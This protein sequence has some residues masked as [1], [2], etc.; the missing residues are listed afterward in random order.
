MIRLDYAK[1]I[2]SAQPR[3][4]PPAAPTLVEC[5]DCEGQSS[6]CATCDGTGYVEPVPAPD[7]DCKGDSC[8][9]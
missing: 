4:D 6:D 2:V 7:H 1:N 5:Q 8:P 9:C 3:L